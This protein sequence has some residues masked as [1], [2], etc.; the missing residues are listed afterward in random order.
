M[1][2]QP[3]LMPYASAFQGIDI[4]TNSF[5]WPEK[6]TSAFEMKLFGPH[7]N[8]IQFV[9][10]RGDEVSILS[11]D[12]NPFQEFIYALGIN[13]FYE[14]RKRPSSRIY[15]NAKLPRRS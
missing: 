7:R 8:P 15:A 1:N 13:A 6:A 10:V 12:E 14:K 11:D 4:T 9:R 3:E 5:A 2:S